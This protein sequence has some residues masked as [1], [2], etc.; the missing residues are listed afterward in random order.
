M[1]TNQCKL[2]FDSNVFAKLNDFLNQNAHSKI[3]I[4]VDD[5]TNKYC[6][7]IFKNN[8]Q[9]DFITLEINSGEKSKTIDTVQTLWQ[10]LTDLGADRKSVFINLGGGVVTDLGGFVALTFKRGIKYINIPTT[11]LGMVDAAIG[12][13]TGVDFNG[14]KNQIGIISPAEMVLIDPSFLKTLPE[15]E[16]KS[17]MAEVYKY[18]LIA[19]IPEWRLIKESKPLQIQN[20]VIYAA[21][22]VK[23][24]IV[25]QDPNEN[26]LRKTLNYGHT[27]GHAIETLFLSKSAEEQL[28]HG[29]AIAI[30]TIMATYLSYIKLD[31]PKTDLDEITDF[32]IQHYPKISLDQNDMVQIFENLKHD[33]KNQNGQINFVLLEKIGRPIWD[34]KVTDDEILEAINF[35]LGH[36]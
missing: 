2:I 13:K 20:E 7:P 6:L 21:A 27:L 3:F 9:D 1:S 24:K 17:G 36:V 12:G 14:L 10:E 15:R 31:F 30:G 22:M 18:S 35:Y 19:A 32:F 23:Q 34:V 29:E 5:Q 8:F 28:L 11:L 16:I 25:L 4:L 33:K 26:G